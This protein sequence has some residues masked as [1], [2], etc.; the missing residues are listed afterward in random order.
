MSIGLFLGA[1]AS[2][3]YNYK[4]T[5]EMK[6]HILEYASKIFNPKERILLE[7]LVNF[8][9][10]TDIEY[11]LDLVIK[12]EEFYQH[13]EK[14]ED[15]EKI[16][17]FFK[18]FPIQL[19]QD[20]NNFE[21]TEFYEFGIIIKNVRKKL[22]AEIW[23]EYRWKNEYWYVLAIFGNMYEKWKEHGFTTYFYN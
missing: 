16:K 1:G 10:C 23:K 11:V 22:E 21:I 4:T 3:P 15:N 19:Q 13:V 8:H 12:L 9:T 20:D 18:Q 7:K 17:E 6:E 2:V 14:Y 5:L